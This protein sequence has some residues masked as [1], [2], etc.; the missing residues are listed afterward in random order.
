MREAKAGRFSAQRAVDELRKLWTEAIG[1]EYRDDDPDEFNRLLRD[2]IA[3]ADANGTVDELRARVGGFTSVENMSSAER[4]MAPGGL[5]HPDTLRAKLMPAT[6]RYR[7]VSARELAQPVPPMRW[8]V[9]GMWPELSA[10]VLGGEKENVENMDPAGDGDC[11]C[12]GH[13]FV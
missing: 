2:A 3:L 11:G 6:G 10:G 4:A 1:G 13:G 12:R 5:W 8:L 7:L 9:R